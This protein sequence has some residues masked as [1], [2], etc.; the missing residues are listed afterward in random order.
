MK[1]EAQSES[2]QLVKEIDYLNNILE[3]SEEENRQL[4]KEQ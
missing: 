4:R 1:E 2:K 3:E